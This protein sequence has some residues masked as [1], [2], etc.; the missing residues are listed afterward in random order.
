MVSS[1]IR[2][3]ETNKAPVLKQYSSFFPPQTTNWSRHWRRICYPWLR[4]RKLPLGWSGFS[5]SSPR[6]VWPYR[7]M[8]QSLRLRPTGSPSA[9]GWMSSCSA[10]TSS[11]WPCTPGP[12]YCSGPV[13]ASPNHKITSWTFELWRKRDG[14]RQNIFKMRTWII[15]YWSVCIFL[16][17][18]KLFLSLLITNIFKPCFFF[19]KFWRWLLIMLTSRIMADIWEHYPYPYLNNQTC[20]KQAEE[21]Y[22]SFKYHH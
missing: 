14:C 3:L 4:S 1:P 6:S 16:P 11:S 13:G 8:T 18:N 12:C 5:R 21:Q 17:I 20:C 9:P 19:V 7:R 22:V 2:P 10:F 15:I